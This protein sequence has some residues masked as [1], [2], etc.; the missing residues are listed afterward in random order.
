[1]G[2]FDSGIDSSGER[3]V[4]GAKQLA[5]VDPDEGMVFR[6]MRFYAAAATFGQSGREALAQFGR[7]CVGARADQ[8]HWQHSI[9]LLPHLP[10][11][12]DVCSALVP[13]CGSALRRLPG[14]ALAPI[15]A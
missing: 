15:A 4:H 11:V 1:M 14:N 5:I 7:F 3:S 12:V 2:R 8:Q 6:A 13:R 10:A 9:K